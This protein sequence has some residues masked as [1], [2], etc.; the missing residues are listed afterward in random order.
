MYGE[1]TNIFTD[2]R[3]VPIRIEVHSNQEET[4]SLLVK[5]LDQHD[6]SRS[7]AGAAVALAEIIHSNVAMREDWKSIMPLEN[8][9]IC[10][11]LPLKNLAVWIDPIGN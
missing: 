3:G 10:I 2:Q 11:D 8:D 6:D 9:V 1:E 4:A 7:V 5:L